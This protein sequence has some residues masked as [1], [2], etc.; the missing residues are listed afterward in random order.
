MVEC[1]GGRGCVFSDKGNRGIGKVR[2]VKGR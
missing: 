2:N 1:V